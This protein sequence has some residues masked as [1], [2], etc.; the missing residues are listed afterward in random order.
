MSKNLERLKRKGSGLPAPKPESPAVPL[1]PPPPV[2][3]TAA[4]VPGPLSADR[5]SLRRGARPAPTAEA[6]DTRHAFKGRLPD[7]AAYAVRYAAE[8]KT[9]SGTLTV[10][11]C[12]VFEEVSVGVF[13]LLDA[14]DSKYRQWAIENREKV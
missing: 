9:W 7:G 1:A 13:R 4:A 5:K 6:C 3:T 11:G 12:P 8:S 10:P 14:L 2:E